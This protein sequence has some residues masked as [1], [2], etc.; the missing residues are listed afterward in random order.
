MCSMSDDST[1]C[2]VS[3][4]RFVFSAVEKVVRSVSASDSSFVE[5]YDCGSSWPGARIGE[6]VPFSPSSSISVD[7]AWNGLVRIR[8]V[9]SEF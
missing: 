5:V 1:R 9:C 8:L 3:K 2:D 4:R 7:P 6:E